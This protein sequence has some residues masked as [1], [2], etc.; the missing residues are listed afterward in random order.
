MQAK[1]NLPARRFPQEADSSVE[2]NNGI[3]SK[4]RDKD[5]NQQREG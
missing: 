1:H 3:E 5:E 2:Y 4:W